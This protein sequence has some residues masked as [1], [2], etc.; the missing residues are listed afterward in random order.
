MQKNACCLSTTLPNCGAK[1]V[2]GGNEASF[3]HERAFRGLPRLQ[4][5]HPKTRATSLLRLTQGL[6]LQVCLLLLLFVLY[7]FL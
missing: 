7:L 3:C 5:A 6:S 1:T 2:S 4:A